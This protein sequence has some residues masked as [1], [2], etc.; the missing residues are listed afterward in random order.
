MDQLP[1]VTVA[2]A[3]DDD[4]A[5]VQVQRGGVLRTFEAAAH[6]VRDRLIAVLVAEFGMAQ[7]AAHEHAD[8][9]LAAQDAKRDAAEAETDRLRTEL[10]A[11]QGR[12]AELETA[13]AEAHKQ[14]DALTALPQQP[15][16]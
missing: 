10:A 9:E 14:I 5:L 3:P 11:A 7:D 4:T 6:R 12:I 13:L 15:V 1:A 2:A 16:T 8:A